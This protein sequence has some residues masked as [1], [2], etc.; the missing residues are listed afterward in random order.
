MEIA[1]ISIG[2]V[3]IDVANHSRLIGAEASLFLR[4]IVARCYGLTDRRVFL[5]KAWSSHVGSNDHELII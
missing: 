4:M 3:L 5:G 1:Q 2:W